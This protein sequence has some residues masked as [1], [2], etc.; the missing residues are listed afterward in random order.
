MN[1]THLAQINVARAQAAMDTDLMSGFANRL[2]EINALAD[3]AS[4]FVWR[5]QTEDGD[6]TSLQVF[7]DPLLL[8]NMSVWTNVDALKHFVYKSLHVDLIRD[9]DAWFNKMLNAHQALWWIPAGHRPSI[10][11]GKDKLLHLQERLLILDTS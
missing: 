2:D 5:L 10:Q 8:I 11:E 4:G 1:E 9:R 3:D 6:A 7:D